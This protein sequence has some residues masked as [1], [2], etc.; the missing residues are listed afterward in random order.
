MTSNHC[1]YLNSFD[2]YKENS[3]EL[4]LPKKWL[5]RIGLLVKSLAQTL[6]PA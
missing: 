6:H 3:V 5:A 2:G 1:G 4:S